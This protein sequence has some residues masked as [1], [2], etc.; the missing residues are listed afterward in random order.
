MIKLNNFDLVSPL[1]KSEKGV[2]P[3]LTFPLT[4]KC[5]FKCIY[6][7]DGGEATASKV[8]I[9]SFDFVVDRATQAYNFGIRKFR[10][11]GGEPTLHADFWEIV[12][13]ISSLGDDV[14]LLVNTNAALIKKREQ[15]YRKGLTNVKFAASLD[16]LN[17]ENFDRISVTKGYFN[18]TLEGIRILSDNGNLLRINMVVNRL[19]IDEVFDMIEFCR[20][21]GTHLKLLDVVSVPSPHQER[22]NLHVSTDN[23]EN[24]LRDRASTVELHQYARCFGT[25]CFI[26]VVDGVRITIKSTSHGSRY[27]Q[28]GVCKD[29][30]YYPCHEGLYDMFLLPDGRL[31]GCR[32]S[33]TSVIAAETFVKSLENITQIFQRADWHLPKRI[34]DMTPYPD[35]IKNE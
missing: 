16:S 6:C 17:E 11:T 14:F 3:Y 29:C 19:N 21:I 31:C 12:S 7:G 26:Y 10:L 24:Q 25:P 35:F 8:N 23:L 22:K 33:E 5:L 27:D 9:P 2:V 30:S 32:W 13:F 28:I 18:D 4:T 20:N 1:E 34:V 15:N